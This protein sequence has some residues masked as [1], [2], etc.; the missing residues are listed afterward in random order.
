MQQLSYKIIKKP[1]V[2]PQGKWLI[3]MKKRGIIRTVKN[4]LQ[5]RQVVSRTEIRNLVQMA[6]EDLD[7]WFSLTEEYT[8]FINGV[9]TESKTLKKFADKHKLSVQLSVVFMQEDLNHVKKTEVTEMEW[10]TTAW[11]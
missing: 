8:L 9:G 2:V 3:W 10:S 4:S 6:F 5:G 11:N 7:S 1:D